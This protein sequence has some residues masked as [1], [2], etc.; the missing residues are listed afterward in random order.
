MEHVRE[1]ASG[2]G[3]G[4]K[5]VQGIPV[6]LAASDGLA[7]VHVVKGVGPQVVTPV[8]LPGPGG[9]HGL[10]SGLNISVMFGVKAK[11]QCAP[12]EV[13]VSRVVVQ[14]NIL[15]LAIVQLHEGGMRRV[16]ARKDRHVQ[17]ECPA[18]T[19]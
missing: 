2:V 6:I 9:S 17:V 11:Y 4:I 7:E 3:G 13:V 16:R 12:K 14:V 5:V 8:A 1:D 19:R 18:S 15:L 10:T